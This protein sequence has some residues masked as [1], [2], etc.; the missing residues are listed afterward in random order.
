MQATVNSAGEADTYALLLLLQHQAE[1][2]RLIRD[3]VCSECLGMV[4]AVHGKGY[5]HNCYGGL[6]ADVH[7]VAPGRMQQR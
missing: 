1:D 2:G 7:T 5:L 4:E 6:D 3:F